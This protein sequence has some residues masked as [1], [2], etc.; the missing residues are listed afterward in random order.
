MVLQ[1]LEY[2]ME[3]SRCGSINKAAQNLSLSQPNLSTSIKKL[4]E[5]L[6]FRVFRRKNSGIELTPEG[7]LLLESAAVILREMEKVRHIPDA[8]AEN[9]NL[10][11]VSTYSALLMQSFIDFKMQNPRGIL[12]DSFKETGV[13][14]SLLDV[15]EQQY[16]MA[17]IYCFSS[18]TPK[19]KARAEKYNLEMKLLARGIPVVAMVGRSGPLAGKK[20]IRYQDL[21]QYSIATFQ[22]FD[23]E[24]WLGPLGITGT[25]NVLYV[26]D[27]G[28]LM[29]TVKN[30]PYLA[31][32]MAGATPRDV[33]DLP[34][35]G[36]DE[37]LELYLLHQK[38]YQM[39]PREKQ[40][41]LFL[42]KKVQE[43]LHGLER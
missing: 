18:T 39:N 30:S 1:H 6:G 31:V 8:F 3:I 41:V 40:L 33:L 14:R 22:N 37:R 23:Y 13:I 43:M 7:K 25:N 21:S 36:F 17:I 29:D 32:V 35:E 24:D 42:R 16:R 9:R 28:G 15:V 26:F 20:S 2:V 34:I 5:D 38:G 19:Q 4:E 12:Q 11:I 27:R 10:S